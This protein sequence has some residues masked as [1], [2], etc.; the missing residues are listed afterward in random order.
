[1][2]GMIVENLDVFEI[3]LDRN[4]P[5]IAAFIAQYGDN[6]TAE[7][8]AFALDDSGS[9]GTSFTALRDAIKSNG[10]L[11]QPIIVNHDELGVYTVIEGNTRLKIY[12][13]F[14]EQGI[15]GE[16]STIPAIVYE[17]MSEAEIHTIRLQAHL[18]GPREWSRY[19][20]AKY[21]HS[22][23]T[24]ACLT[25]SQ[26]VASC[27][28]IA[29]RS[30]IKKMIAA[31]EDME[32][33][34][35]TQLESDDQFDPRVFSHFEEME[36]RNFLDTLYAF[37][38]SKNDFAKWV[39]DGKIPRAQS[40]RDISTILRQQDARETF[41]TEGSTTDDAM[42]LVHAKEVNTDSEVLSAIS[43]IYL[44]RE[45]SDRLSGIS[46]SA[47]KSLRAHPDCQEVREFQT[48][49]AWIE[50]VIF[51]DVLGINEED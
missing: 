1:M 23:S 42:K 43:N 13:E 18:V 25:E 24:E 21:L 49:Q 4:N 45:L 48:L 3:E 34:Y 15:K 28:G 19:A 51:S 8:I 33:Y 7:T 50:E 31:Y 10:G 30:E 47:V 16:W 22:L 44:A 41:L 39:I 26:I 2:V 9:S 5:R 32:K 46:N 40:V 17:N 27:G 14:C 12:Q 38:F 11:I 36:K 20:K 6:I 35:R 29:K 37:D